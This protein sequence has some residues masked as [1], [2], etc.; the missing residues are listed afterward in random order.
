MGVFKVGHLFYG[1]VL[2]LI[3]L[4]IDGAGIFPIQF[5]GGSNSGKVL[6]AESISGEQ[7]IALVI[8]NADY[9]GASNKL[10][11]PVNDAELMA[12]TLTEVG[13]RVTKVLNA[14]RFE[15]RKAM[16]DYSRSLSG[17]KTIG[18][19]YYAGHG[20]QVDGQNYL[21]P[22]DASPARKDELAL[23]GVA[24]S[25]FLQTLDSASGSE[26]RLNV[27]ILDACRNNP[28]ARGWR[29]VSR[30]LATIDAPSGTLIAFATAPG[31]VAAD[32]DGVNSPY[33]LALS[34]M[35]KRPGLQIEQTFKGTRKLVW[36]RTAKS[37]KAQIPWESTS[38]RG[39]FYFMPDGAKL[40]K[41]VVESGVEK[42]VISKEAADDKLIEKN[43]SKKVASI[44]K[45]GECLSIRSS[46]NKPLEVYP[47][48]VL[49]SQDGND[50][51]VIKRVR[52]R[53]VTY[54]VNGG[55]EITCTLKD[56][57]QFNWRAAPM[58]RIRVT[59]R[60]QSKEKFSGFMVSPN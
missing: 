60:K 15:M 25:E 57:C 48:L 8:G 52:K 32:G 21:L 9:Q 26:G 42:K 18:L 1:L 33:T 31:D 37:G 40:P 47:G 23:H 19:F 29:S 6:A 49:C 10:D 2:G 30:G 11:N 44:Q 7:R 46:L 36:K 13:F 41:E 45:P 4:V 12:Q 5:T 51:A 3:M 34:E 35:I 56:L 54:S 43:R 14:T 53:G 24:L 20:M 50:R 55:Y 38:L 22:I 39:D 27:V 28:F 58:F 17:A 16:L 59:E